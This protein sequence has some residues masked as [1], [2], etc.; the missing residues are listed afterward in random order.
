MVREIKKISIYN[1]YLYLKK[2]C[3]SISF[4]KQGTYINWYWINYELN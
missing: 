1:Y 2:H 3:K 4:M